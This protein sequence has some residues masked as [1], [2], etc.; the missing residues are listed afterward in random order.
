MDGEPTSL[1]VS[2][3]GAW[4]LAGTLDITGAT[5]HFKLRGGGSLSKLLQFIASGMLGRVA[6]D[7][8]NASAA[9]GLVL[10]YL[11]ALIWT[12]VFFVAA[13]AIPWLTQNA[14]LSGVIYAIFVWGVMSFIVIPFSKIGKRPINVLQSLI[15]LCILIVCIGLP[16][17]L[18]AQRCFLQR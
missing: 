3:I 4:L 13:R 15:G 14:I 5:I 18:L 16:I 6:Y 9:L 8:G 7:K 17:A 1:F 10:H 12:V 2:V 11:F